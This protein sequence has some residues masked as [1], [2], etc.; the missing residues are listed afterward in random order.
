MERSAGY[1]AQHRLWSALLMLKEQTLM[2]LAQGAAMFQDRVVPS[3]HPSANFQA[4]ADRSLT[5][6]ILQGNFLQQL[7]AGPLSMDRA[8]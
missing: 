4:T 2:I 8:N 6:L 3:A 1:G 7:F 5:N